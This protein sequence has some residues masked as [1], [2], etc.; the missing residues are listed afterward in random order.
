VYIMRGG[1]GVQNERGEEGKSVQNEGREEGGGRVAEQEGGRQEWNAHKT[2][3][4]HKVTLSK[5]PL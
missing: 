5:D 3:H 1:G 4:H 2:Q